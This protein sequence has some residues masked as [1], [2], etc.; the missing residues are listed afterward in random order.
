MYSNLLFV[1]VLTVNIS[2]LKINKYLGT[3]PYSYPKYQPHYRPL[4][5][6]RAFKRVR[7]ARRPGLFVS[8]GRAALLLSW[9]SAATQPG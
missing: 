8:R 6:L 5:S 7:K 2:R 9:L 3:F 1:Y 4:Q